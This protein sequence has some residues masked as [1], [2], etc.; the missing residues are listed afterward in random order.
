[1][2]GLQ[3]RGRNGIGEERTGVP[4]VIAFRDWYRVTAEYEGRLSWAFQGGSFGM[5]QVSPLMG[6]SIATVLVT[7]ALLLEETSPNE[8]DHNGRTAVHHGAIIAKA[9]VLE[10]LL[11]AGG[12]PDTRDAAG[13]TPLHTA[14]RSCG[15]VESPEVVA[16][17]LASGAYP[18]ITNASGYVPHNTAFGGGDVHD[19][20]ARAGGS[21]FAC[22][23]GEATVELD[24]DMVCRIQPALA[25]KGYDPGPV[26]GVMGGRIRSA[27]AAWQDGTGF[28]ATGELTSDEIDMQLADAPTAE[29]AAGPPGALYSSSSEEDGCWLEVADRDD[30]YVRSSEPLP[31]ETVTWSDDC[32]NGKASETGTK[33]SA[34]R[35][36]HDEW[37]ANSSEG[38]YVDGLQ[39][40]HWIERWDDG[41]GGEGW[42]RNGERDGRWVYRWADGG[43][44]EGTYKN[45]TLNGHAVIRWANG[46]SV[47]GPSVNGIQQQCQMYGMVANVQGHLLSYWIRKT[48]INLL[49][50]AR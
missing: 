23:G 1:M 10:A 5:R 2:T 49:S 39:D 42:Y 21:D 40:G 28:P 35:D 27:I 44:A 20:P 36:W 7:T 38:I 16:A 22:D 30:C 31:D 37:V 32:S 29:V 24:A 34:Y 9:A 45:G 18:C 13:S 46:T 25:S 47:E 17:L 12:H 50:G 19:M 11:L 3:F 26:D 43:R 33:T 48:D 6:T 8:P 14:V 4:C 41:G 15:S